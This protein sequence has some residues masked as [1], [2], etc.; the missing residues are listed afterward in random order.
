MRDFLQQTKNVLGASC[1]ILL[2]AEATPL[3]AAEW[4]LDLR[5]GGG[6][7][8]SNVSVSREEL[9]EIGSLRRTVR[10]TYRLE[11]SI[12]SAWSLGVK[13]FVGLR[14]AATGRVGHSVAA[15]DVEVDRLLRIQNLATGE[16]TELSGTGDRSGGSAEIRSIEIGAEYH[17][18]ASA[19]SVDP[20]LGL[21]VG[22]VDFQGEDQGFDFESV[23][24]GLLAGAVLGCNLALGDGQS[25]VALAAR[26][27]SL[28]ADA[29]LSDHLGGITAR[30]EGLAQWSFEVGLGVRLGSRGNER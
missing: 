4:T 1:L 13:R 17:L 30:E 22:N 25:F 14:W 16:V 9:L 21:S 2:A 8:D 27:S 6:S 10:E 23:D 5:V 11:P 20:Y 28:A 12:E 3:R 24:G 29:A 18:R 7:L 26:Y 15:F 19:A